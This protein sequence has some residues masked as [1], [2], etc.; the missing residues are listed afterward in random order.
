[1]RRFL[2][3]RRS[4]SKPE[5]QSASGSIPAVPKEKKRLSPKNTN[6]PHP[7]SVAAEQRRRRFVDSYLVS[8]N[9]TEAGLAAGFSPKTAHSQGNR[10][11]KNVE[12]AAEIS[13][14]QNAMSAKLEDVG[15]QVT[16]ELMRMSFAN[17]Q[18]YMKPGPHGEPMLDFSKLTRDQAAALQEVTVEEFIDGRSDK[19]QVRRV[20]FKL[21][22]KARNIELLCRRL[23]LFPPEQHEH[24]H[25]HQHQHTLMGQL[26]REI[27]E[28]GRAARAID[29]TGSGRVL[30]A[31]A[32][33][34]E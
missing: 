6:K 24:Q 26:L 28:E 12:V 16:R 17:M 10:L 2:I 20:K 7:V 22:D 29:V 15:E 4:Q 30:P 8:L 32:E 13:R 5:A 9:A 11:L 27:D 34:A 25:D 31:P 14:R 19:R 33:P 3:K 1:M 23:A 18:D 21:A